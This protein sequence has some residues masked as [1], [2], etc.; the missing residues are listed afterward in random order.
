MAYSNLFRKCI[1]HLD[2]SVKAFGDVKTFDDLTWHRIKACDDRRHSVYNTSRLFSIKLPDAYSD[3]IGYHS[4]C[5]KNFTAISIPIEGSLPST[6]TEKPLLRS[7]SSRELSTSHSGVFVPKCIFCLATRKQRR[8]KFENLGACMTD[9]A[10][11]TIREA[12][13]ALNDNQMLVRLAGI[14]LKS[15]EVKYHHKLHNREI[16]CMSH[17][18]G[19]KHIWTHSIS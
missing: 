19:L 2:L 12:A 4:Q 14:D 9:Q 13:E 11:C 10:E 6:Y 7:D 16:I 18:L 8:G 3:S 15:K 1:L 17:P 5:Y